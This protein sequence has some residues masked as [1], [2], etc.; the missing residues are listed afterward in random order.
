MNDFDLE[1]RVEDAV[2]A[3]LSQHVTGEVRCYAAWNFTAPQYPCAIAHAS[4]NTGAA[5]EDAGWHGPRELSVEVEINVEAAAE[6]DSLGNIV[7]SA[8]ECNRKAR[9]AVIGPLSIVGEYVMT[10]GV[11]EVVTP[12]LREKLADMNIAG[13]RFSAAE[14]MSAERGFEETD[15][16]RVMKTTLR[17]FVI[18]E[19]V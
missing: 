4:T 3:Y 2:A 8:R 9:S 18:A 15:N 1:E 11:K 17:L 7:R 5:G 19:S 6:K 10:N 13:V 12:G 16:R 14:L